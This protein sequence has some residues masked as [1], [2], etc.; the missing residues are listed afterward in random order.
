MRA[1]LRTQHPDLEALPLQPLGEG[2]DNAM[3][4]LGSSLAVRVPRRSLAAEL[5]RHEQRWLG[6]LAPRLPRAV[7]VGAPTDHVPWSWTIVRWLPGSTADCQSPDPTQATRLGEFF[8]ALH[9]PPPAEAPRNRYRSV[10]LWDRAETFARRLNRLAEVESLDVGAIRRC[11]SRAV[12]APPP[13]RAVWIH[14]DLH[15]GNLVVDSGRVSGVLD[16]G[17]LTAGDPA[18]D[19]AAV[20]MSF[21]D[22]CAREVVFAGCDADRPLRVRAGGWSLLFAVTLLEAVAP[23]PLAAIARAT[24][25]RLLSAEPT[26]AG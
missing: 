21:A 10:P 8:R 18:T 3:F 15:P 9:Q 24:L 1:L 13:P 17:D 22:P 4:R 26:T 2:W 12:E 20:W 6:V 11:W 14:G 23:L 7:R 16:W 5:I 19:L 25:A